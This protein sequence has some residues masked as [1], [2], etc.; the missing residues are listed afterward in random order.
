MHSV[1]VRLRVEDD[2]CKS[3]S[4]SESSDDE[5]EDG[6]KSGSPDGSLY[7]FVFWQ[8]ASLNDACAESPMQL[9]KRNAPDSISDPRLFIHGRAPRGPKGCRPPDSSKGLRPDVSRLLARHG[10]CRVA[11]ESVHSVCGETLRSSGVDAVLRLAF[12]HARFR[13]AS[14]SRLTSRP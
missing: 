9:T 13:I 12:M 3:E 6:E 7:V 5:Y 14:H 10:S 2:G 4:T 11:N 1:R 8:R